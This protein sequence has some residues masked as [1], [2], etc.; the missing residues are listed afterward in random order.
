MSALTE[1]DIVTLVS[2]S[3]RMTVEGFEG[4]KINVVW[5]NE[6]TVHR[7][8]FNITLL[9]KFEASEGG[10]KGGDRGGDRGGFKGGGD[11]GGFKGG[12]DRGGDRGGFKGGGDR[13][14]KSFDDKKP[15]RTFDD[16]K[17]KPFYRKD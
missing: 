8:T 11:R 17:E 2:G 15:R 4:K 14:G 6:G 10:F 16:R 12:G 1:G 9:R 5:I 13:G 7:D 3:P